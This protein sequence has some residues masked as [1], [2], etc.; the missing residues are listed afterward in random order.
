MKR[1]KDGV[2]FHYG[3]V[4]V[5]LALVNLMFHYGIWYSYSVLMLRLA[6]EF[7]WDRAAVSSIFSVYMLVIG[8]TGP[9]VGRWI[10]KFGSR[11]VLALGSLVLSLGLYCCSIAD[12]MADFYL[13]FGLIAGVGAGTIGLTGNSPAIENWFTERR[14]LAAGIA[15][16][17]IGLGMLIFVPIVQYCLLHQS[18]QSTFLLLSLIS[19]GCLF[20][21]NLIL[22]RTKIP[23]RGQY[24]GN[25]DAASSFRSNSTECDPVSG[26][27]NANMSKFFLKVLG[28]FF[29]GGFIVQCVLMHQIAI[30]TDAGFEKMRAAKILGA[31]GLFGTAGRAAWGA[32]SDRYGCRNAYATSSVLLALGSL[33]LLIV[34][35]KPGYLLLYLYVACF[36]LGYGAIAPLNMLIAMDL[37]SGARFGMIYGILFMA[38]AL[39]AALGPMISGQ[40]YDYFSSYTIILIG[41]IFL[42]GAMNLI[43]RST[44]R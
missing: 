37:F 41:V 6:E 20:P 4:I 3:W 34:Q 26:K 18:W 24:S 33:F 39:G 16:S 17:G 38:T 32:I 40:I 35:L 42:I 5:G 19:V 22:Q 23:G 12:S 14:G 30:A 10:D 2:R 7:G 28:I 25:T 43:L 36:G 44:Y 11:T 21:V 29:A 9:L 15:T 27:R 31:I 1:T 8:A 13:S